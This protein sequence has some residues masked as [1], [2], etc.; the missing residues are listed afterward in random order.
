V[1]VNL[2]KDNI[3]FSR[4][5]RR[6]TAD[7]HWQRSSAALKHRL[8]HRERDEAVEHGTMADS[9]SIPSIFAPSFKTTTMAPV[10]GIHS[11][12]PELFS[13][14]ADG[15]PLPYRPLAL[16][17]LASATRQIS[18][19][20]LPWLLYEHVILHDESSLISAVDI[21]CGDPRTRGVV[22]GIY[23][24]AFLSVGQDGRFP[25]MA[26]LKMLFESG[27]FPNLK[28]L[29][30]RLGPFEGGK[31]LS[32]LM[33]DP[34]KSLDEG[35]WLG[36]HHGCPELDKLAFDYHRSELSLSDKREVLTW[37]QSSHL[38]RFTVCT[39]PLLSNFS[40]SCPHRRTSLASR[41]QS[42]RKKEALQVPCSS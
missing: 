12:P 32:S 13:L 8:Q 18:Q 11:L 4:F 6:S 41:F 9:S 29:D 30:L 42:Y 19:I 17:S 25:A 5:A 15:L 28:T 20:V 24:R 26:K 33:D 36:L 27:G 39:S 7:T 14:I 21:I 16:R 40:S 34:F 31:G 3:L 2:L 38:H 10:T 35:F 22:R 1:A 23:V 37:N